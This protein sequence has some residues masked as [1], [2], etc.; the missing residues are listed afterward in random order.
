MKS[1]AL[2]RPLPKAHGTFVLPRISSEIPLIYGGDAMAE[3]GLA[4]FSLAAEKFGFELPGGEIPKVESI[5][6]R[7]LQAWMDKHI[8]ANARAC[9]VARPVIYANATEIEFFMQ[10]QSDLEL[11]KLKPVIEALEAE[12]PGLGWYV[13]EVIER[14]AGHGINLYSPSAMGYH[15]YGQFHGAESDEDF[16]REMYDMNGEGEPSPEQLA[17]FLA[18]AKESYSYLPSS[19]L[20]SVDGHAHLLGW[21][22]HDG[23]SAPKRLKARQV[24]RSLRASTLPPEL[25]QCVLDA[26]A[27]DR[28]YSKNKHVY[29]WD[30]EDD[31]I[32]AACFVGWSATDLMF[33]LA[34]HYETDCYNCGGGHRMPVA[35]ESDDGRNVR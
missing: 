15:A 34:E 25:Q 8:G 11:L 5:V 22:S 14:S 10:A 23:K 21:T 19:V 28:L 29:T 35:M 9:L 33:E 4:K 26:I 1:T 17:T 7:Q 24:S 16:V 3:Q 32:G 2:E 18:E 12:A 6:Q 20:E 31:Q 13:V 30:G 27:L